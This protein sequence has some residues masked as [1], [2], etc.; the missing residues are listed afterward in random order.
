MA[1]YPG[2]IDRNM[3]ELIR[4]LNH[5]L[6]IRTYESCGGHRNLSGRVNPRPRG[7]FYVSFV[8]SLVDEE[9]LSII[10]EAIRQ[11]VGKVVLED[12][13]CYWTISGKGVTPSAFASTLTK[14]NRK[15][16]GVPH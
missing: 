6:K 11:F 4:V 7:E 15:L 10:R 12:H 14:E 1:E 5:D 8:A 3:R 13:H 9:Q 16:L 2:D